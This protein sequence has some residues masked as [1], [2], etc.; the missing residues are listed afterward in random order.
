MPACRK[1]EALTAGVLAI[2]GRSDEP[3][4]GQ[5]MWGSTAREALNET[6]RKV[7]E[8]GETTIDARKLALGLIDSGRSEPDVLRRDGDDEGS[9]A[10]GAGVALPTAALRTRA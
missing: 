7:G 2:H 8:A 4:S 1:D 3:I 6:A 5:V 10:G 9:A